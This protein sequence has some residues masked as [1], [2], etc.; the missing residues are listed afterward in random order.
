MKKFISILFFLSVFS[1]LQ[2]CSNINLLSDERTMTEQFDDTTLSR[3]A[4]SKVQ[5][6]NISNNDMRINFVTNSGYLLVLGQIASQ[7]D[8]DAIEGKLNTLIEIKGIYNQM[9]IRKPIDFAQQSRDSWITAQIKTKFT[10]NK[11]INPFQI[12]VVTENSEVFLIAKI[13][14]EMANTAT[15]IARNTAGVKQVNRVFQLVD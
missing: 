13:N 12:K 2:G 14:K 9:R 6:L 8:K 7:Q 10:A 5:E 4:L 3:A 15:D 11:R 1:L